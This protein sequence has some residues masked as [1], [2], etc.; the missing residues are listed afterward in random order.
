MFVKGLTAAI[1][2]VVPFR[3][4]LHT[5]VGTQLLS[6]F[7]FPRWLLDRLCG[8]VIK[9]GDPPSKTEYDYMAVQHLSTCVESL[10]FSQ[11]ETET[12]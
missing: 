6:I 2:R 4:T 10:L 11:G 5:L 9:P 8:G 3:R 7:P 1:F 12:G